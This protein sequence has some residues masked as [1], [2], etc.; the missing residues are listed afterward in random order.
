MPDTDEEIDSLLSSA[1]QSSSESSASSDD[2]DDDD[3]D[4]DERPAP[5]GK[6]KGKGKKAARPQGGKKRKKA[7][8]RI[9]KRAA[10][11]PGKRALSRDWMAEE[12]CLMI[13][14]FPLCVD[15]QLGRTRMPSRAS[16]SVSSNPGRSP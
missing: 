1:E 4:D 8:R 6:G 13:P 16:S 2:D 7:A 11:A 12:M 9:A 10:K 15:E 14:L 3:D 5:K